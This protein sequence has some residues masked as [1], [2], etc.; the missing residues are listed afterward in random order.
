MREELRDERAG[1]VDVLEDFEKGDDVVALGGRLGMRQVL[2]GSV[3]VRQFPVLHEERVA[4]F[5]RLGD[6]EHTRC[7]VDR[8]DAVCGGQ[9]RGAFGE[10]AP[11]APDVEVA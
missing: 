11:A 2:D 9:A 8:G 4:P 6:L 7:G 3:E 10:D 5:V 1:R